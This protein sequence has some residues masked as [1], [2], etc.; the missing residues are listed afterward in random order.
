MLYT[1]LSKD[2]I[3]ALKLQPNSTKKIPLNPISKGG[4]EISP[5]SA[6]PPTFGKGARGIFGFEM[7]ILFLC[8]CLKEFI[9]LK[10]YIL[11]CHI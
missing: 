10:V 4:V 8:F 3:L 7:G 5:F 6:V 11:L 2:L 9:F 1:Q